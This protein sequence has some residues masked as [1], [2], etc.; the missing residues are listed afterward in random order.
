[1][2]ARLGLI[3]SIFL[4][5]ALQSIAQSDSLTD[6]ILT[7]KKLRY[8]IYRTFNEFKSNSPGITSGLP[9]QLTPVSLYAEG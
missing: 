7:T 4:L 2:K 9:L 5:L 1:M 6:N 3:A 8:G